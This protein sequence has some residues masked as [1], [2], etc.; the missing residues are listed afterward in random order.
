M[1]SASAIKAGETFVRMSLESGEVEKGLAQMRNKLDR[2]A[3]SA[4]KVGA[5][6]G[7][8]GGTG[9]VAL[10]KAAQAANRVELVGRRLDAVFRDAAGEARNF[11]RELA[12]SIGDSRFAVEDT[13]V[14]FKSFFAEIV[15]SEQDQ[16]GFSRRMTELSR[17]F[18]AFQ[19]MDTT[20][21][22]QRFISALSGSPEVLD[23]FGINLKAAALDAE[24]AAKGLDV[25]TESAREFEKVVARMDIIERTMSKQGAIGKAVTELETFSGA[26]RAAASAA[27]DFTVAVG[28][29][30]L[31]ILR[32]VIATFANMARGFEAIATH[33]PALTVAFGVIAVGSAAAGV[34]ILGAAAAA[35]ALGLAIAGISATA[36]AYTGWAKMVKLETAS[37]ATQFAYAK[38][39]L[40][41]MGVMAA[42]TGLRW[43]GMD[44]SLKKSAA[45]LGAVRS[46]LV[47][48][49]GVLSKLSLATVALSVAFGAVPTG[50]AGIVIAIAA[51]GAAQKVFAAT[52]NRVRVAANL[53]TGAMAQYTAAQYA[54]ITATQRSAMWNAIFI[55]RLGGGARSLKL[56]TAALKIATAARIAF[57]F[58]M[59]PLG[60]AVGAIVATVAALGVGLV[61]LGKEFNLGRIASERFS[62]AVSNFSRNFP[63]LGMLVDEYAKGF[64]KNMQ[65]AASAWKWYTDRFGEGVELI[66][67]GWATVTG[68]PTS[69]DKRRAQARQDAKETARDL[70][71]LERQLQDAR[72]ASITDSAARERAKLR[73]DN[74]RRL[75][76]EI[77]SNDKLTNLRER[78]AQDLKM[79]DAEQGPDGRAA[80]QAMRARQQEELQSAIENS[81]AIA[82]VRDTNAQKS[83]N[84]ELKLARELQDVR[85]NHESEIARL[86]IMRSNEGAAQELALI[87]EWAKRRE[88]AITDNGGTDEEIAR[89]RQKAEEQRLGVMDQLNREAIETRKRLEKELTDARIQ[90]MDDVEDREVAALQDQFKRRRADL[91]KRAS[92]AIK[93]AERVG[94]G[95]AAVLA[96]YANERFK[97]NQL[98]EVLLNNLRK[99]HAKERADEDKRRAKEQAD[100]VQSLQDDI[101]KLK[102]DLRTPEGLQRTLAQ[103]ELQRKQAIRDAAGNEVLIGKINERSDLQVRAAKAQ[104][105]TAGGKILGSFSAAQIGAFGRSAATETQQERLTKELLEEA[106]EQ[107]R[108]ERAA[109]KE[110]REIKS[111]SGAA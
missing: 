68:G 106:R 66:K 84:L 19:G 65:R 5:T 56:Y 111:K 73:A 93:A 39:Q 43:L 85:R 9:V 89:V 15:D 108:L 34:A 37:V 36:S 61:Q 3:R 59:S 32:P 101:D 110:L 102:I 91:E 27:R 86:R 49:L 12:V 71:D 30:L 69:T 55:D 72:I 41:G 17:D 77:A 67:D 100:A 105:A 33:A 52:L 26:T 13:L 104:S 99:K 16:I 95:E 98:Y 96:F 94:K 80:R 74:A 53:A 28:Q 87:D 45:T 60:M 75:R 20:E 81:G 62:K 82:L 79:L 2:F 57:N 64:G 51:M 7:A 70:L 6:L 58:A 90:S 48:T 78:H 88:Q 29:A 63:A 25:T 103:I 109:L 14:T 107:R 31:P 42:Q 23:R 97:Q 50:G 8:I 10:T 46:G 83:Y 1:P 76:D 47:G 4:V 44:A 40:H 54:N 18:A 35:T 21:A 22:L 38:S 24:F 92:D 11:A